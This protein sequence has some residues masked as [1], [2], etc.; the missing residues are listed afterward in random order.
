[1]KGCLGSLFLKGRNKIRPFRFFGLQYRASNNLT[2]KGRKAHKA[3]KLTKPKKSLDIKYSQKSGAGGP[4]LAP[5]SFRSTRIYLSAICSL[6]D[7]NWVR[8]LIPLLLKGR[9]KIRPF[10]P[11]GLLSFYENSA[12]I[13]LNIRSYFLAF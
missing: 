10:K 2:T 5:H 11:F 13:F 7:N 9:N 6:L 4:S 12:L 8:K 3:E 1:M